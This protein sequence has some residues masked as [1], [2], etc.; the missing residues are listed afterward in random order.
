MVYELKDTA[1][2]EALFA[3]MLNGIPVPTE[4]CSAGIC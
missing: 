2:A 1:R 4:A 3:E